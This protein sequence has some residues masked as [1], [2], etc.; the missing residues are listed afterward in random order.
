MLCMTQ[1]LGKRQRLFY[2]DSLRR[3]YIKPG[4]KRELT[5]SPDKRL[6]SQIPFL[7]LVGAGAFLCGNPVGLICGDSLS[8]VVHKFRAKKG[9]DCFAG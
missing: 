4:Q 1:E 3:L 9:I 6:R 7:P 2:G 8:E 5:A